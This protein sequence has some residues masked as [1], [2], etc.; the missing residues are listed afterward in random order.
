[1]EH[2]KTYLY[3]PDS[4]RPTKRGRTEAPEWE[5]QSSWKM[6]EETCHRLWSEQQKR[7]QKVLD[8]ANSDTLSDILDFLEK[9]EH[10]RQRSKIPCGFILAGSSVTTQTSFFNQLSEKVL[11][12][13]KNSFASISSGE[14]P[15]LKGF[16]KLLIRRA[17]AKKDAFDGDDETITT[18][19]RR[20]LDYDL[21]V[22]H[23]WVKEK[24]IQEV[25]VT[26]QDGEAFDASLLADVLEL[27]HL[28]SNRIPFVVL[29]GLATSVENLHRRLPQ[30]IVRVLQGRQFDI[31]Q[32]EVLL[33]RLYCCSMIDSEP[34]LCIGPRLGTAI[35]ER[36]RLHTQNPQDFVDELQYAY[37][38]HFFSN[39]LS[40]FLSEDLEWGDWAR[41]HVEALRNLPSFRRF[42]EEKVKYP[43]SHFS[44]RQLLDRDDL[45][46]NWARD[47][48]AKSHKTMH[49]M[50]EAAK[51]VHACRSLV[52]KS[53]LLLSD[54]FMEA[55]SGQL[56][57]ASHVRELF[58]TIKRAPSD[59]L[60][61]LISTLL[62]LVP[63]E[64]STLEQI[65]EKLDALEAENDSGH[66]LKS[67]HDVQN[68]TLR[69]TVV[70]RRVELSKLKASLS[71]AD[72]E[73]TDILLQFHEWLEGY[74]SDLLIDPEDVLLSEITIYDR[75]APHKLAFEPKPRHAI[76]RALFA[77]H[78]Y[79]NCD[80][81]PVGTGPD[82]EGT[83]SF[84][85]PPTS[86]LYQLHL[87][88][89]PLINVSDLFS[90]FRAIMDEEAEEKQI[91]YLFQ[92]A[93][94]EL[95]YLG[96]VK[97][98]RK[99]TDHIAKVSWRGL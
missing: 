37:M 78:D 27:T 43:P 46:F 28:W 42:A 11:A 20:L 74:L 48:V 30:S 34:S 45:L 14:A 19:G 32:A 6:R 91:L 7:I 62:P 94:A 23:E 67:E 35:L 92:R 49:L 18:K 51:V 1:M 41:E 88:S 79:L 66:P 86:I 5:L 87:E 21:G 71:K 53:N 54:L 99:K 38:T 3:A 26:F 58:L 95:K 68:Q 56:H 22:L 33:E 60:S 76:E 64:A 29:I 98:T 50:A 93:L 13:G 4:S 89:G 81:C 73:Y 82:S 39:G 10:Q 80:C 16:L 24:E 59:Q 9:V 17:I 25:V 97:S 96:M 47:T 61:R 36:I 15:N 44:V 75:K 8:D 31:V 84:T 12:S 65:Q 90:A 63:D 72:A 40:V 77:P 55:L 85:Q 2:Q 69:A 70:A 83:L 52:G 57:D